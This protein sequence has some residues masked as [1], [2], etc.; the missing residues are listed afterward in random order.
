[1]PKK[2]QPIRVQVG[3]DEREATAEEIAFIEAIRAGHQDNI[4]G[5]AE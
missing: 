2:E 5:T 4:P 1:M 3:D